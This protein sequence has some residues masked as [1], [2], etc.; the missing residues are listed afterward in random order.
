[1]VIRLRGRR[2]ER[3]AADER[4]LNEYVEWIE[5]MRAM[6]ARRPLPYP[7]AAESRTPRPYRVAS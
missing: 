7:R 5:Q 4:S 6:P 1:M 2:Q 3:A